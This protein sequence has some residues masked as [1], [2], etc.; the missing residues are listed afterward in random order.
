M[1]FSTVT[2]EVHLLLDGDA[3]LLSGMIIIE[4]HRHEE[5]TLILS[6]EHHQVRL[7]EEDR[8]IYH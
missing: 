1:I 4:A 3:D 8:R 7:E 6:V 5:R 2:E